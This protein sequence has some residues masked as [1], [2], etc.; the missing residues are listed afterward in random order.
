GAPLAEVA[1]ACAHRAGVRTVRPSPALS[2]EQLGP[3]FAAA[4]LRGLAVYV[5][6]SLLAAPTHEAVLETPLPGLPL[7]LFVGVND[8]AALRGLAPTLPAIALPPLTYTERLASW[9]RAIP[10][11]GADLPELARR[12]R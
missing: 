10:T 9:Q 8:R 5:P 6:A 4:W 11:A 3:A 12:F 1:A 2:R 7:T